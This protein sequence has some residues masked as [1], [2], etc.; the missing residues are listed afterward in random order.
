MNHLKQSLLSVTV[1]GKIRP[2]VRIKKQMFDKLV[3]TMDT[4][5]SKISLVIQVL[6]FGLQIKFFLVAVVGLVVNLLQFWMNVKN[7]VHNVDHPNKY[8]DHWARSSNDSDHR[9]LYKAH[10]GNFLQ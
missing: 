8:Q 4:L 6:S 7:K 5:R 9:L 1:E 2:V 3:K 10:E